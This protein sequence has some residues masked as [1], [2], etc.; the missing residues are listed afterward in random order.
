MLLFILGYYL[1]M[2]IG[3]K[4]QDRYFLPVYP[5]IDLIAAFGL[6]W[7]YEFSFRLYHNVVQ[8][9]DLT[10]SAMGLTP[11]ALRFRHYS[12]NLLLILVLLVN[13]YLV[14]VNFP[15]YFT[16]YNPFLGGLTAAAKVLTIGWGEGLDQAAAYLNQMTPPGQVRVA[17]W[18]ESTFAPFYHGPSISYSKE[19]GKVLA[20]DYAIFYINQTQRQFPD[21]VMFDYFQS[22]FEPVK[23]ITL[24]GLDYAWIYPSLGVDHYGPD[25]TYTGIASLLAWQW[26]NGDVPLTSGQPA[27]FELYWEYLGKQPEEH[28]FFRLV[29]AQGHPWAEGESQPVTTENPPPESWR[30]GE[31][32]FDRG[33]LTPPPDMPP[34]QYQLQLGFYT[35]APAVTSGELLFTIP[36]TEALITIG[37]A[38]LAPSYRLPPTARPVNQPLGPSLTLLGASWPDEPVPAQTDFPLDLYWQINQPLPANTQLHVG[39]LDETGTVAQAWFNLTL[40]ET[41]NPEATTWQPGDLIHTHW[42]LDLLPEAL[43]GKYHFE[44]VQA[45][46]TDVTLPFGQLIVSEH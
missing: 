20:G 37:Q 35:Q 36:P 19:K 39:L 42:Q 46:D 28:L 7:I 27:D 31:I 11:Y 43:P 40:A 22:R 15:Y 34:G 29:D 18:Y 17:S 44:L 38:Q 24:R 8:T 1:L 10:P 13:G 41:F 9:P 3:E 4:K 14:A 45:E 2:T 26:V 32:I 21:E 23:T 6:I 25:Q 33:H 30:E 12:L 16:Y 5:W